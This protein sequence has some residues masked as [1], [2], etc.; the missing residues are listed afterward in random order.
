[1]NNLQKNFFQKS[2]LM[3]IK[4]FEKFY[5]L[6]EGHPGS[7]FSIIDV[8]IVLYYGGFIKFKKKGKKKYL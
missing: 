4:L 8:L 2:S 5:S 6:K 3:R 7:V 1:M